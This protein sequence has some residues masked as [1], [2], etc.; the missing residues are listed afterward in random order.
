MDDYDALGMKEAHEQTQSDFRGAKKENLAN[1]KQY[2]LEAIRGE[3]AA[4]LPSVSGW[5][6]NSVFADT[7]FVAF[8]EG[9]PLAPHL[10]TKWLTPVGSC[11]G[12]TE[13]V[14]DKTTPAR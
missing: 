13:R 7:I 3:R 5:Q 12:R 1:F 8:D 6:S 11:R 14:V 2:V 4:F 9:N 10:L